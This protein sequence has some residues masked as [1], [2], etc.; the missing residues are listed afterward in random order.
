MPIRRV[1]GPETA[2]A[3]QRCRFRVAL[4]LVVVVGAGLLEELEWIPKRKKGSVRVADPT[5]GR[6]GNRIRSP[7][8]SFPCC[9]VV[10]CLVGAGLLEELGW[11]PKRKKG[12]VCNPETA[13]AP[14][15]GE[16]SL[17]IGLVVLLELETIVYRFN[18]GD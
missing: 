3:P 15:A 9:Y 5:R 16:R 4:L 18:L 1:V 2:Y 6:T 8:M 10:S 14:H 7:A 17:S 13:H 12:S 11:I